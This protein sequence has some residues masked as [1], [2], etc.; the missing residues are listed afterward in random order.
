MRVNITWD[1][2]CAGKAMRTTECIVALALK[3]ELRTEFASVGLDDVRLRMDGRYVTLRLPKIVGRKIR[4]WERFHFVIPFSFE[5]PGLAFG[6][7]LAEPAI[8][9]R[10]SSGKV[11]TARLTEPVIA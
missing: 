6:T 4:F 1:D 3:R 11:T 10:E 9:H 8:P 2:I 7:V 5:F